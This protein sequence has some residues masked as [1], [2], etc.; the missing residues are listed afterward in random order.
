ML[1][2]AGSA[3]V[4]QRDELFAF[5][6][7][8]RLSSKRILQSPDVNYVTYIDPFRPAQL[9]PLLAGV[10]VGSGEPHERRVLQVER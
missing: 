4:R 6:S 7:V 9:D 3:I 2:G 5:S 10:Q 1:I 8:E